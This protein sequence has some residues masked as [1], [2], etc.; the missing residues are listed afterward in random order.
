MSVTKEA[1]VAVEIPLRGRAGAVRAVALVDADDAE[2]VLRYRWRLDSYG[3]AVRTVPGT[4]INQ[5][6]HRFLMALPHGDRR[7]VDHI[8]RDPLDNRRCNLRIATNAENHQ[9]LSSAGNAGSSSRYRGV[10]WDKR[11]RKWHAQVTIKGRNHHLGYFEAEEEA[12]RVAAEFRA[13]RMPYS[14][15]AGA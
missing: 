9:N 14:V 6:L 7:Q 5:K 15:E 12:A 2:A 3:Y 8:N 11:Y 10:T 1:R 13:E 4:R